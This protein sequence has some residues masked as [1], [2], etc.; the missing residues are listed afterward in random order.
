[1]HHPKSSLF[2]LFLQLNQEN[3]DQN[4]I[5]PTPSHTNQNPQHLT[6]FQGLS[7]IRANGS[8]PPPHPTPR[9]AP[10]SNK[11]QIEYIYIYIYIYKKKLYSNS[12]FKKNNV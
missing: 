8:H 11:K 9:A 4:Q 2:Y 1:M 7:Y 6:P 5:K 12:L 10:G 3:P